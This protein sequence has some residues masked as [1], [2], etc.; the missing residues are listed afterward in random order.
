LIRSQGDWEINTVL[1]K[2]NH[3]KLGLDSPAHLARLNLISLKISQGS[4]P[5]KKKTQNVN[6]NQPTSRSN[7][8]DPVLYKTKEKSENQNRHGANPTKTLNKKIPSPHFS[9]FSSQNL[10]P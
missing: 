5:K 4:P 10:H 6:T 2:H 1:G 8:T 7:T 9:C 3:W